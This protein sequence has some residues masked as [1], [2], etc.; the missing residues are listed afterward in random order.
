MR[1]PH[2][3]SHYETQDAST[4]VI[5]VIAGGLAA[6]VASSIVVS[7][8]LYVALCRGRPSSRPSSFDALFQHGPAA[9]PAIEADWNQLQKD[10]K[11]HLDGFGWIDRKAGIVQIPLEQAM[12][13]MAARGGN[14]A[15][16][17]KKK[18]AAR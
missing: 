8:V 7:A 1:L 2:D 5:G 3:P 4:R 13:L 14:A 9:H 6:L 10:T 16:A 18:E 11:V 15:P 17:T 12:E